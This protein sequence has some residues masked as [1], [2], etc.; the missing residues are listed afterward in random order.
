MT[1]FLPVRKKVEREFA[2]FLVLF[3]AGILFLPVAVYLVGTVVFDEFAGSGFTDFYA[4]LH[5]ELR[6]GSLAV[7]FLVL[8][9]YLIWQTLRL[10]FFVF[11]RDRPP[12][13]CQ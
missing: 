12:A 8:S 7:W 6:E 10:T 11:R 13:P 2:L 9:P 4:D 3:L 1:R 5:E